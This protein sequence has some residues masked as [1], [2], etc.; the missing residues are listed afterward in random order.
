MYWLSSI[1]CPFWS[2]KSHVRLCWRTFSG[3]NICLLFSKECS[4]DLDYLN[5]LVR[6]IPFLIASWLIWLWVLLTLITFLASLQF[7]VYLKCLIGRKFPEILEATATEARFWDFFWAEN[8]DFLCSSWLF[9]YGRAAKSSMDI[10]LDSSYWRVF[11]MISRSSKD[12]VYGRS[13]V[14]FPVSWI[15]FSSSRSRPINGCLPVSISKKIIP[16]DQISAL[17]EYLISSVII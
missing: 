4:F 10:L 12:G 14:Y 1:R 17:Y 11:W 15:S 8:Q 6:F 2:T 16:K 3:E 9:K 7:K 13:S 5:L